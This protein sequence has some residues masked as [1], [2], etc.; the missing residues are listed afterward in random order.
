MWSCLYSGG[1]CL[2]HF[3]GGALLASEPWFLLK[4][5]ILSDQQPEGAIGRDATCSPGR[6]GKQQA[7]TCAAETEHEPASLRS[8]QPLLAPCFGAPGQM[9]P[10]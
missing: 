7:A 5:G 6:T 3:S 8:H 1:P 10:W 4:R 2:T 9:D